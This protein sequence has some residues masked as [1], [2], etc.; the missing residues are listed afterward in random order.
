MDNIHDV[1]FQVGNRL[2]PAHKYVLA[3]R[4]DFF[5][6]LFLSDGTPLELTDV[7]RKDEDA[8]GL[9]GVRFE[10]EKINV[11]AKKTEYFHSMLSSS[12]IEASSCA[13]LE[14]PIQSEILKVIVD[15]L[16]TDEA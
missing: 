1:T 6:K 7:Y 11:I 15:Y 5:Q 4:S 8:A 12:W 16:Y 2:F 9:D 10:N 14:M 3:V 13:A